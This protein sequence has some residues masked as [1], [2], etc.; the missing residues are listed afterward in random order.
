VSEAVRDARAAGLGRISVDLIYGTPGESLDD[1]RV[2]LDAALALEPDHVSAYSLIVEPGTALARR[3]TR[4]ELAEVEPDQQAD[5]YL[6][7]EEAFS[8]AGLRWY[9]VSNWARTDDQ[10]CE[11]NLSYWRGDDWWGFGPGAHSHVAGVRWW[12]VKH[13]RAYAERL[14]SGSS[15]AQARELLD[16]DT[17]RVER[18]LL[19]VRLSEGLDA[20]ELDAA[21]TEQ[22]VS[23]VSEGLLEPDAWAS[24]R[25]VLTVR[26][27][28]LADLV[29]RRLLVD[30]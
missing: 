23:C 13:P 1:W 16:T 6:M 9:E 11:H 27:R 15:P 7:A 30:A 10:R 4:G 25:A 12:N 2:T 21:G 3:I 17:R 14:A 22:A 18:V 24:G 29:V 20:A 19:E 5:M 28:L 26:G 8:R